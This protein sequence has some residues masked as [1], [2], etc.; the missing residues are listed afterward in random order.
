MTSFNR[1]SSCSGTDILSLSTKGMNLENIVTPRKTRLS[2]ALAKAFHI[3]ADQVNK[4]RKSLENDGIINSGNND[5]LEGLE[6]GDGKLGERIAEEA[7]VAKLFACISAVK[8]AYADLQSA[9]SPYDPQ[10]VQAADQMVVSEFQLLSQLKQSYYY[11]N[12]YKIQA[13]RSLSFSSHENTL[14]LAEIKE[15]KCILKTYKTTAKKLDA[16]DKLKGSEIMFLRAKLEE[17]NKESN[18]LLEKSFEFPSPTKPTPSHFIKCLG[19]TVSSIRSF[20]RVLTLE[21]KYAGWDLDVAA[22]SIQPDVVSFVKASH[23]CYAFESFVTR[24][25]FDGFNHPNFDYSSNEASCLAS[26][27][28]QRRYCCNKYLELIHPD[29]EES[30]FGNGVQRKMVMSGEYPNTAFFTCFV[31]MAKRVWIL[32]D[33]AFSLEHDVSIFQVS[34]GTRFSDVYMENVNDNPFLSWDGLPERES[35]VAFTVLPGFRIGKTF[36]QC[37][38]Y[39]V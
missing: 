12:N 27:T 28:S 26:S 6:G 4:K 32:H 17:A 7:F 38:V 13:D 16:Q 34:K 10:G 1:S 31:E 20:V 15:L 39:L 5:L 35:R 36:I 21:M 22:F 37:Q 8:A 3:R 33:L 29:I 24:E 25:M 2:R 14:F 23:I 11:Y 18:N 30:L 9:Q 19:E